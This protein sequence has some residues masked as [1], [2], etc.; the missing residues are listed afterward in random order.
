MFDGS[1]NQTD[2]VL[3]SNCGIVK[4]MQKGDVLKLGVFAEYS[5]LYFQL[6]LKYKEEPVNPL[7]HYKC[8]KD[9]THKLHLFYSDSHRLDPKYEEL[10]KE[11]PE[12]GC[13]HDLR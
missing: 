9:S 10:I 13:G 6:E 4:N 7:F 5:V 8:P 12:N 3:D 2:L 1:H 11:H